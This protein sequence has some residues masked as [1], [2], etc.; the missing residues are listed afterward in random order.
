LKIVEANF[1]RDEKIKLLSEYFLP[2]IF[3]KTLFVEDKRQ[4]MEIFFFNF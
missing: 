2:S 4:L 3:D 1:E